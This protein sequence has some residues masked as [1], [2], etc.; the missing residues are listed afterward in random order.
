MI[1]GVQ[2]ELFINGSVSCIPKISNALG[3]QIF[4]YGKTG[5]S[6]D[7]LGGR[8]ASN[9]QGAVKDSPEERAGK[10]CIFTD[11]VRPSA[12]AMFTRGT[13]GFY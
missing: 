3:E 7:A 10:W 11:T 6:G 2:G 4:L 1:V 9:V 5:N 13:T 12:V 8:N